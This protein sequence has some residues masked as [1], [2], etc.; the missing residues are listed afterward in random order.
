M[1]SLFKTDS[2]G[3]AMSDYAAPIDD[4][5]FVLEQSVGLDRLAALPA[6][7]DVTPDLV[8]AILE[9]A[10]R[11]AGEVLAP[12]NQPGDRAHARLENGVVRMPDGF[13]EAYA[14]YQAGGWNALPFEPDDGGQGLPW[15]V[16][17]AVQEMWQSANLSFG[18]APILNLGA[19]ELLQAH[20]SEAQKRTW[21]P[22]LMSGA[23]TG[24]MNL[25][26]S[27]AGS[28]LSAIRTRAV[29]DGDTYRLTG[30][31]VFITYGDHDLTDNIV[32]MVLARTPDAPPGIKGISLFLVPKVLVGA[33]G[34][35]GPRNDVRVV[36]LEHKLGVHASPTCLMSF[37]DDGGAIGELI[38]EENRG[39]AC[40]FTMMNNVRL[41]VGQQGVA[42]AERAYQQ[43]RD[44]ARSRV[45]GHDIAAPH[46]G[47][48]TIVHHPDVRRML[49]D[50]KAR[51]EAMRALIGYAAGAL[52]V[53][54]RHPDAAARTEAQGLLDLL[55]PVVKAWCTDGG[56]EVASIGIQVHGG[57][58]YIEETGAAQHFRDARIAPIYEGTNGIQALDLVFRKVLRD[59]G[60]AAARLFAA[61][62][63]FDADLAEAP[64]DETAAIRPCL[65]DGVAALAAATDWV[66]RTGTRDALA[67]AAGA[68]RYLEMF[69]LVVGGFLMAQAAVRAT[70]LLAAPGAD[71]RFLVA[72][73]LAARYYAEQILARAPGLLVPITHGHAAVT[74]LAEEQ[75]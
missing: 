19:I 24:T 17:L 44:Y 61:M 62:R 3:L 35:L 57:M 32:H 37:G 33:D 63:A 68:A 10:G 18:L 14:Q 46:G 52:D 27:Q 26:E 30:Q 39:L 55:T 42:M 56:V 23:W 72:K 28:D 1:V 22:N 60:A 8:A 29:R 71:R 25:T 53:A 49:L 2:G 16:A 69:G 47:P 70:H 4:M 65:R 34:A 51:T 20:G 40:M 64:G 6:Y 21:L 9:E 36:S 58:G 59:D 5:R 75:F 48:V 74:A 38:G 13:R 54:R 15:A 7:G 12:L 66:R 45:Q 73:R 11:L 67:V 31:K 41:S 43:A 50:M